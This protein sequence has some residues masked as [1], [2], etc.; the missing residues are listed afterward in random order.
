MT[1]TQCPSKNPRSAEDLEALTREQCT[2]LWRSCFRT[3]FP[4]HLSLTIAKPILAFELQ[5]R[6]LGGL[7]RQTQSALKA[8]T[9][10]QRDQRAPAMQP[11]SQIVREWNG[12]T[13]RVD[14]LEEGFSWK[15]QTYRSLSAIAKAI[16]GA[17]WSGPRFFG[18]KER[19]NG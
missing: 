5:T 3:P 8:A 19:A 1:S 15:G 7:N 16:T 18:L 13:H 6:Q 10:H 2:A 14:V 11:G 17:H 9:S 4:R 12:V